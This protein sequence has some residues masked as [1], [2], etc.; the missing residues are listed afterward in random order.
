MRIKAYRILII[1]LSFIT[2]LTVSSCKKNNNYI[3]PI[4]MHSITFLVDGEQYQKKYVNHSTRVK[5]IAG[6]DIDGRNF[7]Y[8]SLNES[9]YN[10]YSAV[11]ENLKLNGVYEDAE[12]V[13]VDASTNK[14]ELTK[15]SYD[16]KNHLLNAPI[17]N[18]DYRY[19]LG[20][21]NIT[22]DDVNVSVKIY[23]LINFSGDIRLRLLNDNDASALW[24]NHT[25]LKPLVF[26]IQT[27]K[28]E[29][30][31]IDWMITELTPE[32]IPEKYE[33]KFKIEISYN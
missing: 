20:I 26:N 4:E 14:I 17:T 1:I 8:W 27:N 32:V 33:V 9:P 7:L 19:Y 3:T 16:A 29:Y 2:L 31:M 5:E 22:E 24:Y 6:K 10:F 23:P 18:M 25:D 30:F 28:I 12:V 15:I 11:N 21:E 13:E